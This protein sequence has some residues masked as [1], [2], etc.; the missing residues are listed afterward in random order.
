MVT[1]DV[2]ANAHPLGKI[3]KAILD[4]ADHILHSFCAGGHG[5]LKVLLVYF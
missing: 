5:F 2:D 1:N 4:G 3:S